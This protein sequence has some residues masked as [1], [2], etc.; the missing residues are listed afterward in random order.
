MGHKWVDATCTS[1]KT[2]SV[3]NK[4]EGEPLGHRWDNAS[5]T[6]PKTC[7]VCNYS[8][9]SAEGHT[10][11][12]ASCTEPKTCSVCAATEG[13]AL[14]HTWKNA[15]CTSAKTCSTCNETEGKAKGHSYS[16]TIT[17]VATCSKSGVIT[18]KCSSCSS[19]YT[20]SFSLKEL[21]ANEVYEKSKNSI[22]EILT[23]DKSGNELSLG[24]GFVYSTDGKILTNYHVIEG[25]YSAKITIN[26]KKYT[27]QHVL[28]YD[29]DL[30]LA[31][32]KINASGLTPLNLCKST[33]EV[34][35]TVYAFGSS[36]G[37]TATFSRG[38][39]TY[40]DRDVEGV[41][42]VQHDAA[43]SSG[44]SGGPLINSYGEVIGI[45]TWTLRDSQNL[46]FAVRTTEVNNL[47]FGT[48]LT[49]SEFYDK[50][51]NPL[52]TMK[53]L[54]VEYGSYNSEDNEY[55]V[56]LG[57]FFSDDNSVEYVRVAYY[58]VTDDEVQLYMFIFDENE[59]YCEVGIIFD[60]ID[61]YYDWVYYNKY[62]EHIRGVITA[63]TYDDNTLLGYNYNNI[64]NS[65]NRASARELASSMVDNILYNIKD[66]FIGA[67]SASD[68]GFSRY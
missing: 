52:S 22:G 1:Q 50:E 67:V 27:V 68:L 64:D 11:V 26:G 63:A 28:A 54:I 61:G 48:K 36:Q 25:A 15:T 46:N 29:K 60:I 24:T 66:D 19:K 30:D 40:A 65:D 16:S 4:S 18:F 3:C 23:Y 38:I 8:E 5:C 49:M 58:D 42:C 43:I 34:G 20:E 57:S 51:C 12:N 21:T 47:V 6:E 17:S 44:N 45:N 55:S 10:W 41:A 9:G 59:Y 13:T 14:G 62:D 53:D 31:V 32:I 7:L 39:I 35:G 2:C 33:H 37:L 56:E